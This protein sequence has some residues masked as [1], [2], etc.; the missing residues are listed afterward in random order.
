M[1]DG[2]VNDRDT[3]DRK[4]KALGKG[5]FIGKKDLSTIGITDQNGLTKDIHNITT[6]SNGRTLTEGILKDPD[7]IK[8]DW[9]KEKNV[10][11]HELVIKG[12]KRPVKKKK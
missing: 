7:A 6:L 8:V 4:K 5:L 10:R 12:P 3:S 1:V 11:I 2:S 9:N